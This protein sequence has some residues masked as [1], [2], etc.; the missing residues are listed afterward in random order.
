MKLFSVFDTNAASYE[1]K[2]A[3]AELRRIEGVKSAEVME[4]AAGEVP[5]YCV[6]YDI[7]DDDAEA[8]IERV[9]QAGGQYSSYVSNHAWGAYKKIG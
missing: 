3:V 4:R 7:E 8:T 2:D 6:M 5:R 1:V 9:R